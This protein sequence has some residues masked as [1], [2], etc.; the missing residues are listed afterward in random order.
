MQ[1]G[2]SFLL[3]TAGIYY[4]HAYL[5]KN[6]LNVASIQLDK[7]PKC[8][9]YVYFIPQTAILHL[10]IKLKKYVG[11][12]L[13]WKYKNE[14]RRFSFNVGTNSYIIL[15]KFVMKVCFKVNVTR[16]TSTKCKKINFQ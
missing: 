2:Q 15:H 16:I 4:K 10:K 3:L 7:G 11:K 13:K 6:N 12:Q 8:F 1:T 14:S 5:V 9:I